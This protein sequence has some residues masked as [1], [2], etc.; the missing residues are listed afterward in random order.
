MKLV[1][2]EEVFSERALPDPRTL[3]AD[4]ES[5]RLPGIITGKR[6]YIDVDELK[7]RMAEEAPVAPISPKPGRYR[8]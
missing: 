2:A 6:V 3:R 8:V 5:K 7:R 1:L 4:I